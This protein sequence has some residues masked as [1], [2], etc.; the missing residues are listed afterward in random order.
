MAKVLADV[1]WVPKSVI[2]TR[3]ASLILEAAGTEVFHAEPML[4]KLEGTRNPLEF[5][6][7]S[8]DD[9]GQPTGIGEQNME[10]RREVAEDALA[11]SGVLN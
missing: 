11:N 4:I 2:R 9:S 3:L 6:D 1:F 5:F 7:L 8:E 10:I